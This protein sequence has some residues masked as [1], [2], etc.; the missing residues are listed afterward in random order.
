MFCEK[1]CEKQNVASRQALQPHIV[2]PFLVRDCWGSRANQDG[3]SEVCGGARR[4]RLREGACEPSLIQVAV[5]TMCK[6]QKTQL[7]NAIQPST[8]PA[9]LWQGG[10]K[11]Y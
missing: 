7:L 4:P 8:W 2:G 5:Q 1:G 11:V 3:R 10:F 9:R 6:T